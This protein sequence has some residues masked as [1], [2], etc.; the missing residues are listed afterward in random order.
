MR[1]A[2]LRNDL[3][4]VQT[5]FMQIL[6][7]LSSINLPFA[8]NNSLT[9]FYHGRLSV[10]ELLLMACSAVETIKFNFCVS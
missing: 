4:C 6:T 7:K 9:G 2:L 3:I 10:N 8:Q 1:E 5:S